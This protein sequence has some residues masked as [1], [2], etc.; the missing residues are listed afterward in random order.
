[1]EGRTYVFKSRDFI[2]S[3]GLNFFSEVP[4]RQ[5]EQT[6]LKQFHYQNKTEI[7]KP[8]E[9]EKRREGSKEN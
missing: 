9:E 2:S 3:M 8:K 6:N 7:C 1:M 4:E 5:R